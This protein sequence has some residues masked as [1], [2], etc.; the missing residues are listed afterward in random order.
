M[1]AASAVVVPV[2]SSWKPAGHVLQLLF[3]LLH[4]WASVPVF[5]FLLALAAMLFRPPDLKAFPIDRVGLVLLI[6]CVALRVCA[7]AEAIRLHSITW[8]LLAL[9]LLAATGLRSSPLEA[10]SW[11]LFAAKWLV[12]L[13]L[14]HVA[15]SIFRTSRDLRKIELFCLF[16]LLYLSAVSIFFL[17]GFESLIFPR[18]ILDAGIGIHVDRARGPFLQAVANGVSLNILGLV[19]LNS[20]RRGSLAGPVAMLLCAVVPLAL[21]ATKTRAVWISGA[22]SIGALLVFCQDRKLR[23]FALMVCV[24]AGVGIAGFFVQGANWREF[25]ERLQDQSPVD[26]R[27]EMY[28]AGWQMFAERPIV[29]WQDNSTVQAE[30]ARRVSDFRPDYYVFHNTFLELGVQRGVLGLGLYAWLF[31]CLFRLTAGNPGS[32]QIFA[33]TEFRKLWGLILGVYLINASAVVMNYQFVNGLVFAFA[34]ILS[35][36]KTHNKELS[37]KQAV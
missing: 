30:V 29:G 35:A 31:V 13:T 25:A 32:S 37:I 9:T 4:A 18:Y 12:P 15:G 20:Y 34:G 36:Q 6:G 7:R 22:F 5:F 14:F 8:P 27:S 2:Q 1:S 17:F 21:L 10:Q 26:F 16:V 11:S 24:L 33:D 28:A 23:R 3:R 19:A